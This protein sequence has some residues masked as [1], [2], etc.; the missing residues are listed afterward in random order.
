MA[1]ITLADGMTIEGTAEELRELAEVFG[2]VAEEAEDIGLRTKDGAEEEATQDV[3]EGDY[4]VFN[5]TTLDITKG[6]P[7]EIKYVYAG[8]GIFEIIDDAGDAH[9]FGIDGEETPYKLYRP[10][11]GAP[12]VGDKILVVD[13]A[14]G[15]YDNGDIFTVDELSP[16][17]NARVTSETGRIYVIL[18]REFVIVERA[19]EEDV[20]E[21]IEEGDVVRVTGETYY[22]DFEEGTIAIVSYF[23]EHKTSGLAR[24]VIETE[25]DIDRTSAENLELVA[26]RADRKD[27]A[28]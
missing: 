7:Y 2:E 14:D 1:K 9:S 20:E 28:E 13:V 11:E 15:R 17:G 25:D 4:V 3:R 16:R 10:I 23:D 22:G 5:I 19:V 21:T 6:K 12:Q 18:R 24:V 26:K 8:R 27:L